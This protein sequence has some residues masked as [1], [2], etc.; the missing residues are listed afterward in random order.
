MLRVG[1]IR[2]YKHPDR[3][4]SPIERAEVV[5]LLSALV[6]VRVGAGRDVMTVLIPESALYETAADA[7]R[8]AKAALPDDSD[9]IFA[10]RNARMRAADATDGGGDEVRGV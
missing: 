7:D 1:D 2:F 10:E 4:G 6:A 8:A 5:G 9:G 3:W